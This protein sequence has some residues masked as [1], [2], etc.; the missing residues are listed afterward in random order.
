M[1]LKHLFFSFS[2]YE[3]FSFNSQLNYSD[4][5]ISSWGLLSTAGCL[6]QLA[7]LIKCWTGALYRGKKGVVLICSGSNSYIYLVSF[8]K[9]FILKLEWNKEQNQWLTCY[10]LNSTVSFL[11]FYFQENSFRK[12]VPTCRGA[13]KQKVHWSGQS[14]KKITLEY[15][16]NKLKP[17]LNHLHLITGGGREI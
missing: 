5:G 14:L 15:L 4:L 17:A 16:R 11:V 10:W 1:R 13:Q 8:K 3:F 7:K 12:H 9:A 6:M 2:C